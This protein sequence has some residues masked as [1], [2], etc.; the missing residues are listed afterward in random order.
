MHDTCSSK[1]KTGK[2]TP[3]THLSPFSL[4]IILQRH[5]PTLTT[6]VFRKLCPKD[7]LA[8]TPLSLSSEKHTCRVNTLHKQE[9]K[10]TVAAIPRL[11]Q[12]EVA[13]NEWKFHTFFFDVVTFLKEFFLLKVHGMKLR[14]MLCNEHIVSLSELPAQTFV[15]CTT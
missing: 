8:A 6:C 10:S 15:D 5:I 1:G 14:R 2:V 9:L 11:C 7:V 12:H 13:R 3:V 4:V